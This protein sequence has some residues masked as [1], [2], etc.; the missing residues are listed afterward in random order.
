MSLDPKAD[1]TPQ[2]TKTASKKK[3]VLPRLGK[4]ESLEQSLKRIN[5]QYGEALR[6]LAQ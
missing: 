4:H 3:R 6:R 1:P 2:P 5:E